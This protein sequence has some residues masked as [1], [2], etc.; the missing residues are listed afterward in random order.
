[1]NPFNPE[2]EIRF[3]VPRSSHVTLTIY[4]L[5]GQEVRRL[6]DATYPAG[7][8]TVRWDAK[9]EGGRPVASGI[10][11]YRM[12]GEGLTRKSG[13]RFVQVRKMSLVR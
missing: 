12:Q 13:K 9:D 5:L 8:H 11:L 6:V 7:F 3:A 10:Y 2:T 4:N 1:P